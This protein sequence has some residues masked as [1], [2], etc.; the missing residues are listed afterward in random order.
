[1]TLKKLVEEQTIAFAIFPQDD[2]AVA[3]AGAI[4]GSSND[5][6]RD[7]AL[8]SRLMYPEPMKSGNVLLSRMYLTH[9]GIKPKIFPYY[10]RIGEDDDS[11]ARRPIP[12][13]DREI[14]N[15]CCRW[16]VRPPRSPKPIS[17]SSS[18]RGA[19]TRMASS[20]EHH[21]RSRRRHDDAQKHERP[22]DDRRR[23]RP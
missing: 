15:P 10:R 21:S 3:V 13:Y 19:A 5:D 16:P 17:C 2:T 4:S 14:P 7:D 8:R 1:M 18:M 11:S 9:V 6:R 23:H 20:A 22:R 12:R